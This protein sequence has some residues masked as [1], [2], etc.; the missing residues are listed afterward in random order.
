MSGAA[1]SYPE[2]TQTGS[3]QRPSN[4]PAAHQVALGL[5]FGPQPTGAIAGGMPLEFRS[6][7]Y[8]PSGFRGGQL[9]PLP[10]VVGAGGHV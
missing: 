1:G 8:L 3:G 2:G 4:A 6:D 9:A 5:Q 10:R 7:S